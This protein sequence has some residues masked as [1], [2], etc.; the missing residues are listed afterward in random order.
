MAGTGLS[1]Q[2]AR[3]AR[4]SAPIWVIQR[5]DRGRIKQCF[6]DQDLAEA[7]NRLA[8]TDFRRQT[9]FIGGRFENLYLEKDQLPGLANLLD[10]LTQEAGQ[11]L[12][13]TPETLRTGF[14]LNAMR[15][16]QSTS[17]HSH[18]EN[19]E[20]L[21]CVYYIQVPTSSGD[22]LFHDHPFETRVS[23]ETGM[24]LFFPPSLEHSVSIHQGEGLRLSLACNF[25]PSAPEN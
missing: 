3:K 14:W 25:G 6:P 18:D 15:P 1:N 9:H 17:R 2:P 13:I 24:A 10:L 11:I 16:G 4:S 5:L 21:S 7:F 23:P 12:E 8:T 22:I 20:L 19:D